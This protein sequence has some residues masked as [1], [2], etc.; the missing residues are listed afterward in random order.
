[1]VPC[2]G[3]G[4]GYWWIVPIIMIAMM[5][6]CFFMMRGHGGAMMCSGSRGEKA[7][8]RPLDILNRK[9]ARGEIKKQEY[10][11]K[12]EDIARRTQQSPENKSQGGG[13]K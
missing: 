8:D 13:F 1:M 3:F 10:E 12:K 4:Y 6:L 2:L 9:Y 5:V 7:S 11:E